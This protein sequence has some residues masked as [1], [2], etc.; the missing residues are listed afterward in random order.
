[1]IKFSDLNLTYTPKDGKKRFNGERVRIS[2][3]VNVP[4]EIIDFERDVKTKQGDGRYLVSFRYRSNGQMSKFFT[5][6]DEMKT[7]LDA[8]RGTL[9][10]A[11][12][13]VT[14]RSEP[15]QGGSGTRYYFD[16]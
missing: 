7:M 1:M 5:N 15:F 14:I 8:M 3:I 10:T 9:D 16:D 2:A 13:A 12:I 11:S 4:I 6:S